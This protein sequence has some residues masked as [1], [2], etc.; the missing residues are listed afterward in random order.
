MRRCAR[1]WGARAH[2][3]VWHTLIWHTCEGTNRRRHPTARTQC[4][5][6]RMAGG[7]ESDASE[8][9]VFGGHRRDLVCTS[10]HTIKKYMGFKKMELGLTLNN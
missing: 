6:Q 4:G 8:H 2:S 9:A 3:C 7:V 5:A 10:R 1:P